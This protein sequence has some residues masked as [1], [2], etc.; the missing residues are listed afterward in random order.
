MKARMYFLL[1]I[2]LTACATKNRSGNTDSLEGQQ[3]TLGRRDSIT[4]IGGGNSWRFL[5]DQRFAATNWYSGGAYWTRNFSGSYLYDSK[6]QC[7]YLKYDKNNAPTESTKQKL[8]LI[9]TETD[10]ILVIKNGWRK[11]EGAS[12]DLNLSKLPNFIKENAKFKIE[13]LQK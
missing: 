8:Q 2:L 5:A 4:G 13:Y 3:W 6:S 7:V 9:I 11:S 12:P 1:I 10:T